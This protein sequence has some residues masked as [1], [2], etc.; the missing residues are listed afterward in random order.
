MIETINLKLT[1]SSHGGGFFKYKNMAISRSEIHALI[2]KHEVNFVGYRTAEEELIFT[3]K[4]VENTEV[5]DTGLLH[6]IIKA[7]GFVAY[8]EE[9][10]E[11]LKQRTVS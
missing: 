8:I 10:E 2:K 1:T 5:T 3:L 7:G 11:A 4:S 6:R 9:L